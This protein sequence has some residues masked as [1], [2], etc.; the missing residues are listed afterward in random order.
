[1]GSVQGSVACVVQHSKAFFRTHRDVPRQKQ[2]FRPIGEV[3]L[4]SVPPLLF[5][6]RDEV[7]RRVLMA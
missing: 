3:R 1:M 2:A 7:L 4:W 6:F 5:R